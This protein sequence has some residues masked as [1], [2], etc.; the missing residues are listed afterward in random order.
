MD[1]TALIRALKRQGNVTGDQA[2]ETITRLIAER[3]QANANFVM[4]QDVACGMKED[5]DEARDQLSKAYCSGDIL[6]TI[7]YAAVTKQRDELLKVAEQLVAWNTTYPSSRVYGY[8]DIKQIAAEMDAINAAAK[9][10]IAHARGQ[11]GRINNGHT[12]TMP[13]GSSCPDCGPSCHSVPE[14]A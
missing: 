10:S 4:A 8:G 2:A 3:D 6:V 13:A 7:N 11:C 14:G 1:C 5:L 9:T 12:C